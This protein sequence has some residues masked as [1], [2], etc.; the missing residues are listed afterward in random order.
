MV[1]ADPVPE[2]E[3][4]WTPLFRHRSGAP[5]RVAE[6]RSEVRKMMS[7]IGR[8]AADYGAHSLRIGGATAALAAGVDPSVIRLLGRWSSDCY[9][10]Y[11]RL[12][13]QVAVRVGLQV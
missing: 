1:E 2:R 5:L 7:A 13:R 10:I 3:R 4:P 9:E 8:P 12:N 6:V 11:T